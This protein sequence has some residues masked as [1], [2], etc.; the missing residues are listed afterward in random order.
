MSVKPGF[1]SKLL[2]I[3]FTLTLVSGVCHAYIPPSSFIVKNWVKSRKGM[4]T[5]RIRTQV[6]KY[7]DME[8]T[9]VTFKETLY[10]NPATQA[11]ESTAFDLG[12][13][14]LYSV[15]R[16]LDT[17]QLPSQVLLGSEVSPMS[18]ALNE[19]EIPIRKPKVYVPDPNPSASP[20]P[21]PSGEPVAEEFPEIES[22]ARIGKKVNPVAW[23]IGTTD[24]LLET[25]KPQIWFEKDKFYPL[26]VI[27]QTHKDGELRQ[28][29]FEDFHIIGRLPFPR[30]TK[31][32]DKSGKLLFVSQLTDI[33]AAPREG[34]RLGNNASKAER[35][36]PSGE[37]SS[38]E[39]RE[40]IQLYYD[41][42]R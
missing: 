2:G 37:S 41:V 4:K 8:P 31:V 16:K 6:T 9:S 25:T 17:A 20:I 19:R 10:F 28:V 32:F 23:V 3:V 39:L 21:S 13:Q 33:L 15:T 29:E 26:K 7:S 12:N 5:I 11:F 34:S 35:F 38:S 1:K 24:P 22:I 18:D 30:T 40:L 27:F 14:S 36:T 42:V